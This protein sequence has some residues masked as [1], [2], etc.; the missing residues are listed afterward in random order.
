MNK[1][2]IQNLKTKHN[3]GAAM[4]LFTLIVFF[5]S[6]TIIV[7]ISR[8]AIQEFA[9]GRKNFNS[10]QAYLLAESGVE[11]A[12]YRIKNN[13]Q[14]GASEVLVLG[15]ATTTTTI[16]NL[17]GGDKEIVS[18][19][20]FDTYQRKTKLVLTQTVGVSFSYGM[21]TGTGGVVMNNSSSII[22]N[23]YSDGAIVGSGS[24][25]ITG[26]AIS[27][28]AS[29]S[30]SGVSV[31]DD[32]IANSV[33]NST[34]TGSLYCQSGSGNNKSCNTSYTEPT[35]Q[36]YPISDDQISSWKAEAEAGGSVSGFDLTGSDLL[37]IGPKKIVGNVNL[38]NSAIM[39]VDGVL[40]ITGDLNLDNTS[41][42]KL[43]SSFGSNG[44]MIVV[45]GTVSTSQS[46]G[47]EKSGNRILIVVSTNISNTAIQ[48]NNGAGS[49]VLMAPNG[50][51]SLSQSASAN[52]VTAKTITLSNS[53]TV[54]YNTG[55]VDSRFSSGPS[56]AWGVSSW[57]E[58][59]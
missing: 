51:V 8:P 5:A 41:E 9:L 25:V 37:S 7:G 31:G 35:P 3:G 59:E 11:D 16:T 29:G 52:Q 39:T 44:G 58:I 15:N 53:A 42:V 1:Q 27:S 24:S 46:G 28:G 26:G 13:M 32:A 21:Q 43:A 4:M 23:I 20:S 6:M 54:T 34:I 40:W 33:T 56:G 12:Y 55:L 47:F 10:K 19:G 45:D 57:G 49:V 14:I 38:S 17:L 2:K 36:D 50:G 30:I 48:L 18:V 22:G